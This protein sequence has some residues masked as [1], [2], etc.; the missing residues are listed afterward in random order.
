MFLILSFSIVGRHTGGGLFSF[1]KRLKNARNKYRKW[2][3]CYQACFWEFWGTQWSDTWCVIV[4]A[5]QDMWVT[6][7]PK[8]GKTTGRAL[9]VRL[10]LPA[11]SSG[12]YN[13]TLALKSTA[14]L[15]LLCSQ[16]LIQMN[17]TL[18]LC[19]TSQLLSELYVLSASM[20]FVKRHFTQRK[21]LSFF[22]LHP[23]ER[24]EGYFFFF[25]P[26]ICRVVKNKQK[27]ESKSQTWVKV[28]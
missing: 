20:I 6:N 11:E 23:V 14:T 4:H 26:R 24:R 22:H 28:C 13:T 1:C 12:W 19:H 3:H 8:N 2:C 17:P 27:N 10:T 15:N 7:M 25:F 18:Q 5:Q 9:F 21:T 16:S